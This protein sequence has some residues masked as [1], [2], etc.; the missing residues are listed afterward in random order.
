MV[1]GFFTVVISRCDLPFDLLK[2][3]K[4]FFFVGLLETARKPQ[5]D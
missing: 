3:R 5:N 4:Y 1:E 2:V